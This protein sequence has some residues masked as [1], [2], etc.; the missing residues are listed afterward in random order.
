MHDALTVPAYSDAEFARQYD[1]RGAVRDHARYFERWQVDAAAVRLAW[2]GLRTNLR[3]G[4]HPR[5]VLDYFPGRPGAPLQV[6]F[7]GGYWQAFDKDSFSFV[8]A[9][10]RDLGVH[11]AVVNYPLC[12]DVS[13]AKLVDHARDA[14]IWLHEQA[15]DLGFDRRRVQV[16]GHSAG[17]H[18]VA[19]LLATAWSRIAP[20]TDTPLVHSGVSLSG[21]FQLQ[22]LLVT[23]VNQAL[24][25]D[26]ATATALSPV[27]MRPTTDARLLLAVGSRESDE[28]HR[29]SEAL[30]QAWSGSPVTPELTKVREAHHFSILTPWCDPAGAMFAVAARWLL[31]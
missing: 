1:N 8:A 13:L 27:S 17:G 29:Q 3:Y 10:W 18:I 6:F 9:P 24:A 21:L 23:P 25:L 16:S 7:H 26:E 30:V 28:Y 4:A 14:V 11:T 5:A 15:D 20:G 12:P 19:M 31:A 22:P 2:K